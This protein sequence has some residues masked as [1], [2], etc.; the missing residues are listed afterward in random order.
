MA[1]F[2]FIDF[3][4]DLSCETRARNILLCLQVRYYKMYIFIRLFEANARL[5]I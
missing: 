2:G 1:C 5:F 4:D 3:I